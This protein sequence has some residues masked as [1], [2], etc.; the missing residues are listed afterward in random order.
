MT[1]LAIGFGLAL[2]TRLEPLAG[3]RAL[4]APAASLPAWTEI[5]ALVVSPLA[6]TILFRAR[7]RDAPVILAGGAIAYGTAR[8]LTSRLGPDLGMLIAAFA[9][10]VFG[11]L[12]ARIARR[13]AAVPIVPSLLMLVPG[14]R[15]AASVASLLAQHVAPGAALIST[16]VTAAA[17]LAAGLLFANL[18]VPPRKAL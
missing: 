18:A 7:P 1:F 12:Y 10:G 13:P 9:T 4:A 5:A 11:N 8:L 15:G 2:L 17:A 16:L 14:T 3:A 6:L